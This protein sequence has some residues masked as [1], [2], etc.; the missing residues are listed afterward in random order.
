MLAIGRSC[1]VTLVEKTSVCL[2]GSALTLPQLRCRAGCF[3]LTDIGKI[4]S[5]GFGGAVLASD[6]QVIVSH[7]EELFTDG[8]GQ[9][10]S[11]ATVRIAWPA[12]GEVRGPIT[13]I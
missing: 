6:P 5:I 12:H 10:W 2:A 4:L 11:P 3:P 7:V 13:T 1:E 8:H 9:R